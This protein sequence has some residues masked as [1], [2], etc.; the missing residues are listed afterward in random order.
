MDLN[1]YNL[2]KYIAYAVNDPKKY[3]RV[4]FLQEER[5]EDRIMSNEE[6]ERNMRRNTITL[7]G[8]IND[9]RGNIKT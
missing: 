5:D 8:T 1:N 6:M 2:G 3:P 9:T 4:P 7:G